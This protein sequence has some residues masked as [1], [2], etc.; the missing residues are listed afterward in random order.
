MVTSLNCYSHGEEIANGITHGIGIIL[1]IA[2]LGV[3]TA[4]AGIY[5]D[6]WHVVSV[7]IYGTTLILLY[8]AST[9]YHSI[10][11]PRA[12][13][14]LQLLDHS[15]IYL[16]IAGTY[17]PFTI[18]SLRGPWGWW[19]FGVVWGLAIAGALFQLSVMRR[20]RAVSMIL[21]IGMGWAI[22]VA[23]KPLIAAVAT[24][25]IVLLLLGGLAYTSGIVFYSWKRL[26]FHH[27]VWHLF[28]LTGSILH[29]FAVLFYVL[30]IPG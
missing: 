23:I 16:L 9:L 6:A 26:K 22:I 29:F 24:G 3:L 30:P 21:Y 13:S 10:Q 7:S 2:A 18:V 15:A 27:A 14:I 28:V 19:L 17:T 8:T 1:A 4:F 12:K 25:G 11:N 5:G 20:Y